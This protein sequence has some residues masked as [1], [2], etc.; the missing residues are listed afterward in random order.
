MMKLLTVLFSYLRILLI[1][2]KLIL[3]LLKQFP[4]FLMTKTKVSLV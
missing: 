1:P 2:T 3:I 4:T